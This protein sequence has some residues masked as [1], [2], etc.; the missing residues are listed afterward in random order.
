MPRAYCRVRRGIELGS[1]HSRVGNGFN[2]MRRSSD[3]M[4]SGVIRVINPWPEYGTPSKSAPPSILPA[5]SAPPSRS[6][7]TAKALLASLVLPLRTIL[8]HLH[9]PSV[10][11]RAI[12]PLISFSPI[13]T[14]RFPNCAGPFTNP[15]IVRLPFAS[16]S[17][18]HPRSCPLP[19]KLLTQIKLPD[20]SYLLRKISSR[21][22]V[23]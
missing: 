10:S 19:P 15:T 5:T 22:K 18:S 21:P 6:K 17:R 9:S 12:N 11:K 4:A 3:P 20:A 2:D 1:N 14:A 23:S 7:A 13:E 16:E 8:I